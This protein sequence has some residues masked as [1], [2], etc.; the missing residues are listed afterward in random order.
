MA[1]KKVAKYECASCG[2]KSSKQ[3]KCC[4]KLMKKKKA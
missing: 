4:G 1:K 3:D 2:A